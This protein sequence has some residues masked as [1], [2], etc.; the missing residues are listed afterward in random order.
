MKGESVMNQYDIDPQTNRNPTGVLKTNIKTILCIVAV[1]IVS[2]F[3]LSA[4]SGGRN[5]GLC[6]EDACSKSATYTLG[7]MELCTTHYYELVDNA[8][9]Y[10]DRWEP[11][12]IR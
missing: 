5:D 10:R 7:D 6:D 9:N 4:C 8:F 3:L 12:R 2:I 1:V 11:S